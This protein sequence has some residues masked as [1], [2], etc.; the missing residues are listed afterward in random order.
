MQ[1]IQQEPPG[2]TSA[3]VVSPLPSPLIMEEVKIRDQHTL[4]G[5]ATNTNKPATGPFQV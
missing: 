3:P 5:M 1:D 4:K 2:Q